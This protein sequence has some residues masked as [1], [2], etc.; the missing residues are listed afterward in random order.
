VEKMQKLVDSWRTRKL[1]IQGRI[2]IIKSLLTPQLSFPASYLPIHEGLVKKVNKLLYNFIWGATDKIKR[3]TLIQDFKDGG[4]KMIDL[5]SHFYA[6][7]AVWLSRIYTLSDAKWIHLAKSYLQRVAPEHILYQMNFDFNQLDYNKHLPQFY[8]EV[9][10]GYCA[11]NLCNEITSR[12]ELFTQLLWGNR[13]LTV[14][15]KCLYSKSFL[16]SGITYVKDVLNEEGKIK[17][18]LY[19]QLHT[20]MHYLRVTSLIKKALCSYQDTMMN[21]TDTI[22]NVMHINIKVQDM[23]QSLIKRKALL[24]KSDRKWSTEFNEDI[25]WGKIAENKLKKQLEVKIAEFNYKILNNIVA[26]NTREISKCTVYILYL[27]YS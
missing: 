9:L 19:Q 1:T 14:S 21:V 23:Y 24:P 26:T 16:N 2:L 3:R 7:K 27:C 13:L 25:D 11:G 20:K 12:E 8:R 17:D 15:N 22:P 4:L 10:T 5:E 6:L 18:D